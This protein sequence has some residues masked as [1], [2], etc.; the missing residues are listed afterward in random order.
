MI[1]ARGFL[2][3]DDC[4]QD[5]ESDETDDAEAEHIPE[6]VHQSPPSR[7]TLTGRKNARRT[8]FIFAPGISYYRSDS[9]FA[10]W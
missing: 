2:L 1:V 10:G 4:Q 9:A 5:G 3:A 8:V 6:E 7:R